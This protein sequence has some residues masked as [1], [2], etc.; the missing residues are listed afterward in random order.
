MWVVT[1]GT[2]EEEGGDKGNIRDLVKPRVPVWEPGVLGRKTGG[3]TS[4]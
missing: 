4:Y 2:G 1:G 3:R